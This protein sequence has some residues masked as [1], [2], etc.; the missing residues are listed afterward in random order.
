M[1]KINL[2]ISSLFFV[3]HSTYFLDSRRIKFDVKNISSMTQWPKIFIS[4]VNVTVMPSLFFIHSFISFKII[5]LDY[6]QKIDRCWLCLLIKVTHTIIGNFDSR[7]ILICR[8]NIKKYFIW[9]ANNC[10]IQYIWKI[11]L[12]MFFPK[13]RF[14]FSFK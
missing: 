10:I 14:I 4:F 5:A 2:V 6:I 1:L 9:H 3:D 8:N 11:D 7:Q 12:C 13:Y